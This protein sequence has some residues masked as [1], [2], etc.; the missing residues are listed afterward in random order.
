MHYNRTNSVWQTGDFFPRH[1]ATAIATLALDV[2]LI[3]GRL[4][5]NFGCA[6]IFKCDCLNLNFGHTYLPGNVAGVVENWEVDENIIVGEN[7]R[8]WIINL[9]FVSSTSI[10]IDLFC[11]IFA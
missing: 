9:G 10:K 5:I 4:L 3:N 11:F 8:Y 1:T 6:T 2:L 7:G